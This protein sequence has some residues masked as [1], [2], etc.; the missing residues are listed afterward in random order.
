MRRRRD[1]SVAV[2]RRDA[3]VRFRIADAEAVAEHAPVQLAVAV[4]AVIAVVGVAPV[5][6]ALD[7]EHAPVARVA[8]ALLE[9]VTVS[10]VVRAALDLAFASVI[11]AIAV[12]ARRA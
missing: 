5:V 1:S 6:M 12:R 3:V 11:A 9:P 8:F 7:V 10:A 4:V 2:A